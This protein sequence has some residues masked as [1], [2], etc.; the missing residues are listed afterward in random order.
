MKGQRIILAGGSGFLGRALA[1]HFSGLGYEAVIHPENGG[2][3]R[4]ERHH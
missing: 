1:R 4:R 3:P 2:E